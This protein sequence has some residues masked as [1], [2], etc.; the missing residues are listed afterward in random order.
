MGCLKFDV[1]WKFLRIPKTKVLLLE[2]FCVIVNCIRHLIW[3]RFEALIWSESIII[4]ALSNFVHAASWSKYSLKYNLVLWEFFILFI[5][6]RLPQKWSANS[7]SWLKEEKVMNST[8]N[9]SR[10]CKLAVQVNILFPWSGTKLCS[11]DP[12]IFLAG[13]QR[14]YELSEFYWFHLD[15]IH[16]VLFRF[17]TDLIALQHTQLTLLQ[18]DQD[19]SWHR[20]MSPIFLYIIENNTYVVRGTVYTECVYIVS[21]T[22]GRPESLSGRRPCYVVR[23]TV[24]HSFPYTCRNIVASYWFNLA[25]MTRS[26]LPSVMSQNQRT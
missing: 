26:K 23:G 15:S 1:S 3:D 22:T 6:L 16:I 14:I 12:V 21:V 9:Y 19:F 5:C 4:E 13:L 25:W 2:Y 10:K 24:C 8:R 7:M 20:K 18:E 11:P 17:F